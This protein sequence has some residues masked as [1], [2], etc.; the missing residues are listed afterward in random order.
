[1]KDI[2]P[3]ELAMTSNEICLLG[4]KEVC[5]KYLINNIQ[6]RQ[7]KNRHFL[8]HPHMNQLFSTHQL[9]GVEKKDLPV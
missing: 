2:K 7:N 9:K 8:H 5:R 4:A 1:M 6:D 3:I